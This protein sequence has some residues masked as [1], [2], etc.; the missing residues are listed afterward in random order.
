MAN[1]NGSNNNN[2]GGK[3]G[4]G[5]FRGVL[6][7]IAWALVL[8]VAFNYFNAYNRNATNK[9][10]SHEIKYS[11]MLDL[12]ENDKAKEVLFKDDAIYITPVEGYTYT[13]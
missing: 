8:T 11:E 4:K 9:S 13:E 6:T 12:I 5:N 1:N 3:N 10:T 2:S 7:L